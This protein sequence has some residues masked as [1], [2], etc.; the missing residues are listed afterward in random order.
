[1]KDS[2]LK[3]LVASLAVAQKK[4]DKE[5]RGLAASQKKTDK[6]LRELAAS[7][8]KTDE[9]QQKTDRQLKELGKQI[10]GLSDKF[11]GFTEG[12]ALPSLEKILYEEFAMETV[13]PRA[14]VRKDGEEME[15]DVLAYANSSVNE[16]YVVEVKSKL[17]E[18]GILQMQQIMRRFD[19]F[20]PE[21]KDKKVY[22]ILAAV[23]MS[24]GMRKKVME[25]GF[26][27]ARVCND[28]F[29][30]DVPKNFHP[31]AF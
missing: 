6:E 8:K 9:Q 29:S 22:G 17:R 31:K 21:H 5:L 23:D 3:E 10:G 30:L 26:Y 28:V 27:A 1:M 4:T 12:L 19:R 25:A 13:T 16:A 15:I 7:Q 20:F 14:R 2:E 18:D 11:G 24:K